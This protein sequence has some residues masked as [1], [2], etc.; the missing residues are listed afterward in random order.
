MRQ[1]R[2][3]QYGFAI[4]M[5]PS[6]AS[7]CWLMSNTVEYRRTNPAK[8]DWTSSGW[9][10]AYVP[11]YMMQILGYMCQ[12]YIYWLISCFQTDV[13]GNGRYGG[14][15]RAIESAGQAVSYG[16][17]AKIKNG[18]IMVALN[19]GLCILAIPGTLLVIQ[20]VILSRAEL[21]EAENVV[22]ASDDG[23]ERQ[24]SSSEME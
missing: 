13:N 24:K 19:F 15:F 1:R 21:S 20:S 3:A 14:V 17:N 12:T 4:V 7:F 18:V 16:M 11:F 22:S 10:K 23:H 2:R 8:F 9:A 5:I 6:I